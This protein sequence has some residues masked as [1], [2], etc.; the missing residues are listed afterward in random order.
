MYCRPLGMLLVALAPFSLLVASCGGGSSGGSLPPNVPTIIIQPT[1]VT[2]AQNG[3]ASFTVGVSGNGTLAYQW[4]HNGSVVG[5]NSA[6]LNLTNVQSSAAGTYD[7]AITNTIGS[8]STT[9]TS[10]A[11]TLTVSQVPTISSQPKATTVGQGS[12]ATF[13]VA[14]SA[15]GTLSYQW[16]ENG[17]KMNG[18]TSSTLTLQ[19]VQPS[20][21]GPYSCALTNTLNGIAVSTTTVAA[22]LTV[23]AP[24]QVPL[25]TSPPAVVASQAGY[26]ASVPTQTGVTYA[27]T[28]SNGTITS[29]Q[30]TNQITFT[31]G[32]QGQVTLIVTVTDLGGSVSNIASVLATSSLPITSIFSQNPVLPGTLNIVASTPGAA[33]QVYTWTLSDGTATGTVN[34]SSAAQTLNYSVGANPGTY[35]LA[36]QVTDSSGRIGNDTQTFQV[37]SQSFIQDPHDLGERFSHTATLLNDGRVLVAGGVVAFSG[38][39]Q[40]TDPTLA[41]AKL[42]DPTTNIWASVGTMSIARTGHTATLLNNGQVLVS[43]GNNLASPALAS[44]EVYNPTTQSWTLTGSMSSGRTGHTAILLSNGQV[45]VTGGTNTALATLAT[46]EIYNPATNLWSPAAPMNDARTQHTAVELLDGRVLA[47]GGNMGTNGTATNSAEIYD[48]TANTWTLTAP[49]LAAQAGFAAILLPSGNVLELGGQGEIYDPVT[50]S[51]TNASDPTSPNAPSP[52]AYVNAILLPSANVLAA[53][54][55]INAGPHPTTDVQIYNPVTGSWGAV[56]NLAESRA[57]PTA[58]LLGSGEVLVA[59]GTSPCGT[60]ADAELFNPASGASAIVGSETDGGYLS[61]ASVLK[62][63]RLLATGGQLVC[64]GMVTP[65]ATATIFDPSTNSWTSTAPLPTAVYGHTESVLSNGLV[66]V[67]GGTNWLTPQTTSEL[68]SPITQQWTAAGNLVVARWEHTA[69]VLPNGQVLVAGGNVSGGTDNPNISTNAAEL[70]NPTTVTWTAT[71]SMA[72]SRLGHTA[73]VLANG[74]VLAAGGATETALTGG[75]LLASTEIYDPTAG[76]WTPAGTMNDARE[77]HT[78]TLLPSGMV[79]VAGGYDANGPTATAELYDPSSSTWS[80]VT[81]MSTARAFAESILL[82]NGNVLVVGGYID[83][84]GDLATSAEAYNPTTNTWATAGN[85]IVPKYGFSLSLLGDGRV[86][87]YGGGGAAEF[88]K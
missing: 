13:T 47:A 88:Y 27:W 72:S 62:D 53:G 83:E 45:L 25:V 20:E 63:G 69:S 80:Y 61:A 24:P 3:T 17:A 74:T 21:D 11:A 55:L 16:S 6:T 78:A 22:T 2:A 56:S 29:G 35:Q 42:Y 12:T 67:A 70:F 18:E 10:S 54:G 14:A 28:I 68:F 76:T 50:N 15:N 8:A 81:P 66:L 59:G 5:S 58:T 71:A 23:I 60:L 31:A 65:S 85:L 79:L 77:N 84:S 36:V 26:V 41:T 7:C 19:N 4:H 82:P 46:A 38:A 48:A 52:F 51:W 32:A 39:L 49:M 73:T 87:V 64:A 1:S 75:G 44:A 57:G 34:G 9:A 37:V 30:G 43:G 33:G 40:N 86:V